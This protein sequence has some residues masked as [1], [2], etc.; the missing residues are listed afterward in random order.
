LGSGADDM[1]QTAGFIYVNKTTGEKQYPPTPF[2]ELSKY[3]S[4]RGFAV[5]KYDKR[6]VGENHTITD[7]NVWGN[8]KQN[9][10]KLDAE[11][12]L[13]ILI[14][15]PEV[16]PDK[17]SIFGHSEGTVLAPRVAIDNPDRV[18]KIVLMSSLAQNVS[19]IVYYQQV[20]LPFKYTKEIADKNK[21]GLLSLK[22]ASEDL[23]F[24]CMVGGNISSIFPKGNS[25]SI[26]TNTGTGTDNDNTDQIPNTDFNH[27]GDISISIENSLK[28]A[29]ELREEKLLASTPGRCFSLEGCQ[30]WIKSFL[31]SPVNLDAI[32]K[33]PKNTSILLLNGENDT[34]TPVEQAFLL[35]QKLT[36]LNH[37]DH[38]LITYP[39]LGH[40]FSPSSE[41]Y[42]RHVL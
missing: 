14:Q 24:Q 35:E 17:I 10:L 9:D 3:L 39:N 2:F 20:S 19:S 23:V 13:D 26:Y 27:N 6:G 25:R 16:N 38:L 37:P 28:P 11:K 15:Q 41:W 29:L 21:D 8:M 1:N 40:E 22:E 18:K 42:T 5:L 32:S 31:E 36:E 30:S 33:V 12:A 34:Q 7:G 4:E